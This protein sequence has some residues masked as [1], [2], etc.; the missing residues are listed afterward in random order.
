VIWWRHGGLTDLDNL[1][2]LCSRH[3]HKVHDDGWH[4][5]LG[6]ERQLTVTF[7]DGS[8]KN[9]GPPSRRAV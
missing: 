1:L 5:A 9:T 6:P 8:V 7:P 3:H 4:L 2:P